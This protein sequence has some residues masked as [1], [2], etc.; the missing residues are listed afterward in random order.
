[1]KLSDQ[2]R[3]VLRILNRGSNRRMTC[4]DLNA[5]PQTLRALRRKGLVINLYISPLN[6]SEFWTLNRR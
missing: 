1:M 3:R 5:R 2:Q 6:P 4:A